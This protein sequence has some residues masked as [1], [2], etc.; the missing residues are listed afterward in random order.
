MGFSETHSQN[1]S[2]TDHKKKY[3]PQGSVERRSGWECK[4]G[5]QAVLL[6]RQTEARLL[7]T[8]RQLTTVGMKMTHI[9]V[10]HLSR[11]SAWPY[12]LSLPCLYLLAIGLPTAPRYKQL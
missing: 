6:H 4:T 5:Q 1:P 11:P 7:H 9:P 10:G 12:L 3:P 8:A 2:S